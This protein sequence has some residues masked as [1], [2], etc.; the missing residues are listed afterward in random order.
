[1]PNPESHLLNE[2]RLALGRERDLVLWRNSGGVADR[3]GRKVRFGLV[4]GA[5]DLIG[6]L[7]PSG[8]W[9][10]LEVK[11]ETGRP[12]AEQLQFLDVV[13]SRGGFAC[14]V[15]SVTEAAAAIDRARAGACQ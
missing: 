3:N 2:I 9:V 13:R 7:S 5:S 11:T 4:V 8:R 10:A 15:R 12:T 6:L 14:I 1:M